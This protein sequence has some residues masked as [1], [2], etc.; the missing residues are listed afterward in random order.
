[1]PISPTMREK[2][3]RTYL[4][5]FES[6]ERKRRWNLFDDIPWDKL[7]AAHNSERGAVC[8]ETF[9]AEEFYLPDYSARG[10]D[11]VRPMFGAAWFSACWSYEESKHGLA[12]REYLTRSG[13]RTPGEF[14][15]FE[16]RIFSRAWKLPFATHRQMACYGAL[17]EAATCIA[18]RAQREQ[19]GRDGNPVLEAIFS[20]ISRDEAAHAR[21]YRLMVELE[22]EEDRVGTI[23][24]FAHVLSHFKMP[25]EGLIP[26][27]QERLKNSGA[28][29]SARAFLVNGVLP[30]IKAIGTTRA[31]LKQALILNAPVAAAVQLAV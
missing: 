3:Y 14:A 13:L 17:Q 8:I 27:Y 31:E 29:I 30:I 11:L 9:C 12:F 19:A 22:M 2:M 20:F 28:G 10:M 4:E 15:A 18:Y 24:D 6:A 25:G 5:F 23:A 26:H 16:D 21:F 7:D 1:M